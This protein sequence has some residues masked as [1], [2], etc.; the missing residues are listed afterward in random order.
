MKTLRAVVA[1]FLFS[2]SFAAYP[3]GWESARFTSI[4]MNQVLYTTG[5]LAGPGT[6]QF[7]VTVSA[8]LLMTFQA[9]VIDSTHTTIRSSQD[10]PVLANGLTTFCSP[11]IVSPT[12]QDQDEFRIVSKSTML[13]GSASLSVFQSAN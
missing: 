3:S 4:S 2:L 11:S 9:Q 5:A 8:T 6:F 7:C 12:F 13:V 10:M 1:F